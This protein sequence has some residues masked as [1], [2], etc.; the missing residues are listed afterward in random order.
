[1]PYQP[2]DVVFEFSIAEVPESGEIV[3]GAVGYHPER[4]LF[5]H[6]AVGVHEA[7]DRLVERRV[8]SYD[9]D[10]GIAIV[11]HHLDEPFHAF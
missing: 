8:A 11:D 3:H 2:F 5:S 10:G 6:L 1:M 9:D 7:V 4:D